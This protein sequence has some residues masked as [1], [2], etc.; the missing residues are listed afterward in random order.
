MK[1]C[2]LLLQDLSFGKGQLILVGG[3]PAMGKTSFAR[4]VSLDL[5]FKGYKIGYYSLGH[6]REEW[7]ECASKKMVAE[8]IANISI[9]IQD[10]VPRTVSDI[11]NSCNGQI[12]DLVFVDY[13]QLIDRE[14][15]GIEEVVKALRRLA[16]KM[17]IPIIVLSQLSR[18]IEEREDP[19]PLV[20]DLKSGGID[21]D[22]FD[23]VFLLYRGHYYDREEDPSKMM[24]VTKNGNEQLEWDYETLSVL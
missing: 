17:N 16:D 15:D 3:R 4:S 20:N 2:E 19:I 22:L 8:D 18:K 11:E 13:L 9:E 23:Q 7:L 1:V 5:A 6:K 10:E 21:A 24:V 14:E 12:Y